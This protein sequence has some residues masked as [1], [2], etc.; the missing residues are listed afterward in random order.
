[1]SSRDEVVRRYRDYL[2]ACN[3]RA[4]DEIGTFVAD[5]VLVNGIIRSRSEYIADVQHTFSI[6]PDYRWE[7]R[8]AVQEG[9]WLAVHLYDTGTRRDEFL[10]APGDGSPVE[11]HEFDM[12]RIVKGLIVEVEGTADNARLRQ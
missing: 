5:S 10:G 4:W 7:L 3:R 8:R 2:D 6:F 12:Y 11:T 9:E 1:M